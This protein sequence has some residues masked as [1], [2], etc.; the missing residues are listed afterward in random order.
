MK[1]TSKELI[2]GGIRTD[3]RLPEQAR[4]IKMKV[5]NI[6]S[7]NGSAEVRFGRTVALASVHG[8]RPLFPRHLQESQ[9]GI[10]RVRYN[11]APFSVV[12]RKPPGPDRRSIELS[13]VIRLALEPA[14]FL[15]DY[16]KATVDGFIE[17][18]QADGSTRVTGINALSLALASAGIPMRD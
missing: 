5:G 4:E 17:I 6:F 3:K 9:T 1:R 10:L 18:I 13:K 7:A 8:P 14:L 2:V 15:E 12:D 11:M 16:P